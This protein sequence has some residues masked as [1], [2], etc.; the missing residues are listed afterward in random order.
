MYVVTSTKQY[1][2]TLL[3]QATE[4]MYRVYIYVHLSV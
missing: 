2:I 4:L 1:V 3:L